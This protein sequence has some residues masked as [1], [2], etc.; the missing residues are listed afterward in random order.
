M[1]TKT[2]RLI[3]TPAAAGPWNMAVDEAILEAAG[4]AEVPP[5]LRLYAWT[6]PCLSIG[7]TQSIS[8]LDLG[9]LKS[10]AW[11][12]VR[13]PTG[14]RAILHADEL[15]YSVMAP[16]QEPVVYGSVLDSYRRLSQALLFALNELGLPAFSDGHSGSTTGNS[17]Q[18]PVCFE[19]PSSYEITAKGKKLIGSAQARRRE[20]VLQH[21]SLPLQGDITRITQGLKFESTAARQ[22]ATQ[23]LA[24]RALTVETALGRAVSWQEAARAIEMGFQKT[25]GLSFEPDEL[26]AGELER[27]GQ[28]L[29][30]KYTHPTWLEKH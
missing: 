6:P 5:T 13:R 29:E 11:D 24:E 18:S 15:T 21:G 7:Y 1:P 25:L 22:A 26:T 4:R 10:L 14:G 20:G 23:T 16:L 19:V 12:Y 2:W 9:C 3:H 28:L 17:G 8:D 30:T 27:A